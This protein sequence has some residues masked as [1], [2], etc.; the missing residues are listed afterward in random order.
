MHAPG[1]L[2]GLQHLITIGCQP[3]KGPSVDN[4]A[5]LCI[6]TICRKKSFGISHCI[7]DCLLVS[8]SGGKLNRSI[9][10]LL[11]VREEWAIYAYV[12]LCKLHFYLMYL[13]DVY[14]VR[15]FNCIYSTKEHKSVYLREN[16]VFVTLSA[17]P[18]TIDKW[19]VNWC[20]FG[21]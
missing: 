17:L 11:F 21:A 19:A 18:F 2:F 6:F 12:F 10:M 9:E 7:V 3:V 1:S 15:C 13:S 20:L 4:L 8:S 14:L 5:E 16:H